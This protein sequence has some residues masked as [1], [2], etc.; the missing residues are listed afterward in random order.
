MTAT[1][2][3]LYVATQ[4]FFLQSQ[5]VPAV[6]SGVTFFGPRMMSLLVIN[7]LQTLISEGSQNFDLKGIRVFIALITKKN[8]YH[9]L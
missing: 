9:K 3:S 2:T 8:L 4:S 6:T 1:F 5:G 7:T